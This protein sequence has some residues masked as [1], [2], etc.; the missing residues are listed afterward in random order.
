MTAHMV[1]YTARTN[2][3]TVQGVARVLTDRKRPSWRDCGEQIPGYVTGKYL[4][5]ATSYTLRY[6]TTDGEQVKTVDAAT[7]AKFGSVVARCADRG[8]AWDI[9]VLDTAGNDVTFGFPCFN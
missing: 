8:E 6:T 1:A 7:L 9:A 4:G 3:G 2:L 5:P